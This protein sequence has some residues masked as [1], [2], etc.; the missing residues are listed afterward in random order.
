MIRDKQTIQQSISI[1]PLRRS[2]CVSEVM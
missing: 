2:T 1:Q